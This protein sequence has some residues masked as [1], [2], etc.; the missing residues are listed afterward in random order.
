MSVSTLLQFIL[1]TSLTLF[2]GQMRD[3]WELNKRGCI[4]WHDDMYPVMNSVCKGWPQRTSSKKLL[5]DTDIVKTYTMSTPLPHPERYIGWGPIN[6]WGIYMYCGHL[7]FK[8]TCLNNMITFPVRHTAC[9]QMSYEV[10]SMRTLI[11]LG[12][13]MIRLYPVRHAVWGCFLY[14][15]SHMR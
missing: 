2:S 3:L 1:S 6:L 9:V 12:D 11:D 15:L 4:V 13:I 8:S 10:Y 5:C 7:S 14:W